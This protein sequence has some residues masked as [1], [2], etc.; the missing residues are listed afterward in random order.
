MNARIFLFFATLVLSN[1]II[2]AQDTIRVSK[3]KINNQFLVSS[4][5]S[6]YISK[7]GQPNSSKVFDYETEDITVETLMYNQS[8]FSFS[9]DEMITFSIRDNSISVKLNNTSIK[10]GDNIAALQN[11]FPNSYNSIFNRNN[12]RA[13]R[14]LLEKT[15]NGKTFIS[16][17]WLSIGFNQATGA[18]VSI[19]FV[20][21]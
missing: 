3:V 19:H 6:V 20:R 18:I 2:L 5:K 15:N 14:I 9:E 11:I 13:M 7:L 17:D 16:D 4:A 1:S 8:S 12:A 21:P 10:V